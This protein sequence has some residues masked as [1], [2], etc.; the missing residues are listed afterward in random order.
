MRVPIAS[1]RCVGGLAE[2]HAAA[3]ADDVLDDRAGHA[4]L[5]YRSWR[6]GTVA[7][8]SLCGAMAMTLHLHAQLA[9]CVSSSTSTPTSSAC[10]KQLEQRV[11]DLVEQRLFAVGRGDRVED[12]RERVELALDQPHGFLIGDVDQCPS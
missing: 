8:G 9:A 7:P 6:R 12:L 10:G 1:S 4:Q 3:I 5:G 2:Q 11:D